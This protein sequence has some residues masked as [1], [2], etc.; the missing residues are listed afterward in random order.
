[1]YRQE[2]GL[3]AASSSLGPVASLAGGGR[4]SHQALTSRS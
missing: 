4:A 3:L 2:T 1:M